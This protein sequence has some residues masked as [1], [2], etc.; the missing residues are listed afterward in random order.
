MRQEILSCI[1]LLNIEKDFE[2]NTVEI[3]TD[4]AAKKDV[5]NMIFH[6]IFNDMCFC[7]LHS[8]IRK[9]LINRQQQKNQLH[10]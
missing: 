4:F 5:R 8:N 6:L 10:F 7:L 9:K 1:E 2:I 3:V